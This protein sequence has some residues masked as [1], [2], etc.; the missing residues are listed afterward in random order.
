MDFHYS[1]DGNLAMAVVFL[2]LT[3]R[4][5]HSLERSVRCVVIAGCPVACF[6]NTCISKLMSETRHGKPEW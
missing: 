3:D 5:V 1:Y 2:G 4:S 6:T